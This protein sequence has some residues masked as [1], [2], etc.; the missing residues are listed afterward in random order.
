M[1]AQSAGMNFI[2]H[3]IVAEGV[4]RQQRRHARLVTKVIGE[5]AFGQ[6]GA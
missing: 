1:I 5:F 2:R 3:E 4:H 6:L